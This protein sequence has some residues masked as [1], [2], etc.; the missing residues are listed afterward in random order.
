MDITPL[1]RSDQQVIQSYSSGVFKVSSVSY[2]YPVLVTPDNTE[3][4]VVPS[5]ITDLG[6]ELHVEHFEQIIEQASEID[7]VLLGCGRTMFMMKHDLRAALKEH[8]IIV[9]VM[10]TGAACRTYNVLMAEGRR[11]IA[12]LYPVS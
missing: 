3:R 7:L 12:A 8:G 9:D 5:D 4:W 2:E 10:D 11:L 1:I 6:K